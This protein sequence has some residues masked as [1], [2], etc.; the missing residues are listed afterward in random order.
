MTV[1]EPSAG[2]LDVV[3]RKS[4]HSGEWNCVELAR[5]HNGEIAIRNSRYPDGPALTYTQAEVEAF[6]RSAKDGEFDDLVIRGS[7]AD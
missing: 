2:R 5:L 1:N 7:H 4:R 3:W 6:L